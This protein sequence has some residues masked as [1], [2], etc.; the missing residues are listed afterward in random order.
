MKR[1]GLKSR[2]FITA[3]KRSAVCGQKEIKNLPER[4]DLKFENLQCKGEKFFA[5]TKKSCLSGR[6]CVHFIAVGR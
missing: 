6:Y 5:P 2:I 3:D 1:K 4:Q